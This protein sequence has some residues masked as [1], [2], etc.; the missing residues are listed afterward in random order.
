MAAE[1]PPIMSSTIRISGRSKDI[2]VV[3]AVYFGVF[4][5]DRFYRGQIGLGV[6]KLLTFGGF[7]IW[8]FVDT[9]L[10]LLG[11][12]PRDAEDALIVDQKTLDLHRSGA[13][14]LDQYGTPLRAS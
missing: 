13:Q 1:V 3:L 8:A 6:L 5:V 10:Y 9:L 12:L 7:G 14:I 2:L 11:N 4:G